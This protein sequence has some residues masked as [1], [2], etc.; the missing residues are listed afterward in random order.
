MNLGMMKDEGL[1]LR[2]G[3]PVRIALGPIKGFTFR[4]Q[5]HYIEYIVGDYEARLVGA[6]E[7]V[8]KPG[9]LCYDI[10]AHHGWTTLLLAHLAGERGYVVAFDP[11]QSNIDE[12]RA[13][14]RANHLETRIAIQP[15]AVSNQTGTRKF[16]ADKDTKQGKFA[17][18]GAADGLLVATVSLDDY[19][20]GLTT[21]MPDVLKIDVEGAEVD[22]LRG[23][24]HLLE[25]RR[26]TLALSC[27]NPD[28]T[29]ACSDILED[30]GYTEADVRCV[31]P[32]QMY[33]VKG[34]ARGKVLA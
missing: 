32:D 16:A 34:A 17:I 4:K 1:A 10:G 5:S 18:D 6:L 21:D 12:I 14:V 7:D 11:M 30:V 19:V 26:P 23:A 15:I 13:N 22:V 9:D 24:H 3:T 27:H 31:I 25:V 8:V 20:F 29:K 2:D 28:L 33:L